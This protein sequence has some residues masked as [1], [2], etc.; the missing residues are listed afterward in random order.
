[1]H[2]C[3]RVKESERERPVSNL[4]SRIEIIQTQYMQTYNYSFQI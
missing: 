3:L 4:H 2:V 1:M